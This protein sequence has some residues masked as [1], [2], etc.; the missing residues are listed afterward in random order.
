[1]HS[2]VLTNLGV[3]TYGSNY[4]GQLAQNGLLCSP[5]LLNFGDEVP[6]SVCAQEKTSYVLMQSGN[7]FAFGSCENYNCVNSSNLSRNNS[8]LKLNLSFMAKSIIASGKNTFFIDFD[9]F[10]YGVGLN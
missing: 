10:V 6:V 4:N 8:P 7:V 1:M 2:I 5:T 3:Y 9:G